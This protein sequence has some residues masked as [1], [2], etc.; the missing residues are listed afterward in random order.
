MPAILQW[1]KDNASRRFVVWMTVG[2]IFILGLAAVEFYLG[3][4]PLP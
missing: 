4:S 2:A 3:G 1:G